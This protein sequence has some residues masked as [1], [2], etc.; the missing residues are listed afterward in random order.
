MKFIKSNLF[1][2]LSD[3]LSLTII[4]IFNCYF[5]SAQSVI[6]FEQDS[7]FQ[8]NENVDISDPNEIFAIDWFFKN[9][10]NEEI[11]IHWKRE[12]SSSCPS[13]WLIATSD[14][15]LDY[16]PS[17]NESVV[18]IQMSPVDSHFIVR[19]SF[20]PNQTDGCCEG[21]LIFFLEDEPDNPIDTGYF[22]LE[23]NSNNCSTNSVNTAN[24]KDFI[25]Y[26]N[27]ANDVLF[28]KTEEPASLYQIYNAMGKF[29]D[30]GEVSQNN[31]IKISNL[32]GGI[33]Y[34]ELESNSSKRAITKF[35]KLD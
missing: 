31:Q 16:V 1:K 11:S 29:V 13:E 20:W 5:I 33:Y 2:N 3:Q 4:L 15:F 34:L 17:I 18:P 6:L 35:V 30:G 27:P 28:L 32:R 9:N 10:T 26:P 14:Q 25:V 23:I 8:I 21:K 12:F 22:H 7:I 19:Y 24:R